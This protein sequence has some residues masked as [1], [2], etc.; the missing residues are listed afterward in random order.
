ML[1]GGLGREAGRAEGGLRGLHGEEDVARLEVL[2]AVLLAGV[3]RRDVDVRLDGRLERVRGGDDG[4]V[5]VV[6][7]NSPHW[8]TRSPTVCWSRVSVKSCRR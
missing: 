6:A 5:G 1:V 3:D 8:V 7:T 2:V 4:G